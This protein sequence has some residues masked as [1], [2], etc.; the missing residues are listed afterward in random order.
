MSPMTI[1]LARQAGLGPHA[2]APQLLPRQAAGGAGAGAG[3]P[4]PYWAM[5]Y[6]RAAAR[7]GVHQQL[8][9]KLLQLF[10]EAAGGRRASRALL[11]GAGRFRLVVISPR[12]LWPPAETR[13]PSQAPRVAEPRLPAS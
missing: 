9:A 4:A 6:A 11:M 3:G 8:P 7:G 12:A 2:P 13:G 5:P 1:H 10:V